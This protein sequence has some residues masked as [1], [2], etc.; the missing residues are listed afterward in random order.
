MDLGREKD[1]TVLMAIELNFLLLVTT[2]ERVGSWLTI[3]FRNNG[4]RV[5]FCIT[6]GRVCKLERVLCFFFLYFLLVF[7]FFIVMASLKI[8][9]LL[10]WYNHL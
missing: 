8:P 5:F 7:F 10:M 2:E 9:L 4:F 6:F 3:E 1:V